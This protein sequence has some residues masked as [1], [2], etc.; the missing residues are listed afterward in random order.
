MKIN[1]DLQNLTLKKTCT[2]VSLIS[3][4]SHSKRIPCISL[5]WILPLSCSSS[6][7][8]VGWTSRGHLQGPP[9]IFQIPTQIRSSCCKGLS[10]EVLGISKHWL[11]SFSEQP[12]LVFDS[13][14]VEPTSFYVPIMFLCLVSFHCT[15]LRRVWYHFFCILGKYF[16]TWPGM[17]LTF[18]D[19]RNH[20]WFI[21]S[22][23]TSRYFSA[24]FLSNQFSIS[25]ICCTGLLF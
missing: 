14:W 1:Y 10:T 17:S 15:S 25:L 11:H 13:P 4:P 16:L 2:A 21:F 3:Y 20:C 23:R 5:T 9:G 24:K 8:H 6:Q 19:S 12:D 18:F 7:Y 22:T